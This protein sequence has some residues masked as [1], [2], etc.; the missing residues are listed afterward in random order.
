MREIALILFGLIGL[1]LVFFSRGI[2]IFLTLLCLTCTQLWY[3]NLS[4]IA[5][6]FRWIF[7]ALFFL[8]VFG[9][10]F[11]GRTVRKIK[12]FDFLA[13]IFIVYAFFSSAY[14][15]HPIIT[16]ERATTILALYI[17]VFWI[18]WKYAY[19][20]G[21]EKIASIMLQFATLIFIASFLMIF[22]GPHR[23]F[24][25]G[26]FNGIFWNPNGLGIM[27]AIYLPFS[28]WR[29]LE[30]KKRSAL[31]LFVLILLALILSGARGS[32]NAT[33]VSLGYFIYVHSKKYR[34]LVL[35]SSVSFILI[36]IWTIE[37]FT[38]KFFMAYIRAENIPVLGGR[39]YI[40][41]VALELIAEKPIF[42]YGFGTEEYL[43]ILKKHTMMG[44]QVY[45]TH[46][47][48]LGMTLQLGI[49]GFIL[50]FVPLFI[51]LFKELFS[52]QTNETVP[53]LRYALRATLIA[54]LI[55]AFYESWIY[56]VGN[57]QAFP[58]WITVML[59]VYYRYQEKSALEST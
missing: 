35:F 14:S 40:W 43:F 22:I 39:L 9:D 59:L 29:Y 24:S 47:S 5:L 36:L 46:N 6:N 41:P 49:L 53:P 48:Y 31:F 38:K 2:L 4:I 16:I 34:P 15:S 23:G 3:K 25:N 18:I 28:L 27:C 8:Y 30:T 50:L 56:S 1:S 20:K 57:A 11:L 26:R 7:F 58:Y 44:F 52:R 33:A 19:T 51:L 32:M 21:P 54:G 10:I 13:I 45:L 12:S 42:G 37:I 55:C 17:S